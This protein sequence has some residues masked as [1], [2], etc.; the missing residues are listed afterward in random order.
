[1]TARRTAGK[2][3]CGGGPGILFSPLRG[4]E[5]LMLK[6]GVG[7]HR[8]EGMILAALIQAPFRSNPGPRRQGGG[9]RVHT[10]WPTS[11]RNHRPTSSEC[12][13]C[14]QPKPRG[15]TKL[16]EGFALAA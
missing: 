2:L 9:H 7:D 10:E 6:E 13:I 15:P 8:H 11:G 3:G 1:M 12:A 5:A 4:C 14:R 16:V